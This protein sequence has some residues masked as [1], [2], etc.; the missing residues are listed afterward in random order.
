[1][2]INF[3]LLFMISVC[4]IAKDNATNTTKFTILFLRQPY[5]IQNETSVLIKLVEDDLRAE[6]KIPDWLEFRYLKRWAVRD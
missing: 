5:I 1:M 3:R 6:G 4:V 2:I